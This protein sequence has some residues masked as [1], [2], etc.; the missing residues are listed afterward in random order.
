[1]VEPFHICW[2]MMVLAAV[3]RAEPNSMICHFASKPSAATEELSGSVLP[4]KLGEGHGELNF[5]AISLP[6]NR[7]LNEP[8]PRR[9]TPPLKAMR[10]FAVTAGEIGALASTSAAPLQA[11]SCRS[12]S[13]QGIHCVTL[14]SIVMLSAARSLVRL[15]GVPNA[16]VASLQRNRPSL[17]AT[18]SRRRDSAGMTNAPA[19]STLAE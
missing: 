19:M 1:M 7:R 13:R 17:S 12:A 15:V 10:V 5:A 2:S 8:V 14:P 11:A 16:I 18:K 4:V 6:A 3:M 9:L